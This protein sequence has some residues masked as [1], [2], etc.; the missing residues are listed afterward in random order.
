MLGSKAEFCLDL[1]TQ[2]TGLRYGLAAFADTRD[3]V[4]AEMAMALNLE[5][6]LD[7]PGAAGVLETELTRRGIK[8]VTLEYGS[9]RAF[10]PEYQRRGVQGVLN[11]MAKMGLLPPD[12]AEPPRD[13]VVVKASGIV[14]VPAECG[15]LVELTVGLNDLVQKGDLLAVQRDAFGELLREYHSPVEGIVT[16]IST[17][18]Y[19]TAGQTILRIGGGSQ[20]LNA[21]S[22]SNDWRYR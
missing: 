6:L 9:P 7:D 18:P 4:I 16:T 17:D 19:R 15:G 5:V 8:S 1:H 2:S 3:P 11:V 13:P 21:Q 12:V 14:Q 20:D 10:E 22:T